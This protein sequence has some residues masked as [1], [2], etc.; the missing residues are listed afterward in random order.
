MGANQNRSAR[1]MAE[2][3]NDASGTVC[4][5]VYVWRTLDGVVGVAVLCLTVSR[6][7]ECA[8]E[9]YVILVVEGVEN[10]A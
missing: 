4:V 9:R 8:C 1:D 2:M 10:G 3:V 6:G 5:G 7:S